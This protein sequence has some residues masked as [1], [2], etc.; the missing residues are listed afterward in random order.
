MRNRTRS[1]MPVAAVTIAAGAGLPGLA[2]PAHRPDAT[3]RT[4]GGHPMLKKAALVAA[5]AIGGAF[6]A[7]QGDGTGFSP[8]ERD[9]LAS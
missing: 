1:A 6:V 4:K 2:D 7:C 9:R 8:R 5:A 3:M